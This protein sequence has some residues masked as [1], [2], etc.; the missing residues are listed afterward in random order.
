M[1]EPGGEPGSKTY[2]HDFHHCAAANLR[3]AGVDTT[4]ARVVHKSEKMMW[5]RYNTIGEADLKQAAR[6]LNT[7][8]TLTH[9]EAA[10]HTS[11][12]AIS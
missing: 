1:S 7:Y 5:R 9:Q 12:A 2:F 6:S 4:T 3:R 8:L 10:P 11:N